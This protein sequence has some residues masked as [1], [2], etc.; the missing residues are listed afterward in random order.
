M[1]Q[2]KVYSL[3]FQ[4][5]VFIFTGKKR[6]NDVG[7]TARLGTTK[8]YKKSEIFIFRDVITNYGNGYNKYSGKFTCK[9]PGLYIFHL[10]VLSDMRYLEVWL[11]KNGIKIVRT[12]STNFDTSRA[13]DL[14]SASVVIKLKAGDSVWA[15]LTHHASATIDHFT[16]ISGVMISL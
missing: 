4:K 8:T 3:F 11:M 13:F 5:F 7:F 9:T 14:G 2:F 15:T 16:Y 12:F 1:V 6:S 10:H